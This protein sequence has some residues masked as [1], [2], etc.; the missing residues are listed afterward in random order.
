MG[1]TRLSRRGVRRKAQRTCAGSP[2]PL[3]S[4]G[5]A[6]PRKGAQPAAQKLAVARRCLDFRAVVGNGD[7]CHST[8]SSF[9]KRQSGSSRKDCGSVHRSSF[10]TRASATKRAPI[11]TSSCSL[12]EALSRQPATARFRQSSRLAPRGTAATR[13]VPRRGR[14]ARLQAINAKPRPSVRWRLAHRLRPYELAY[15]CQGGV[16]RVWN[17]CMTASGKACKLHEVRRQSRDDVGLAFDR[18][19]MGSSSPPITSVGHARPRGR[20]AC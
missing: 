20:K 5:Q 12:A 18:C 19:R 1:T 13:A 2:S 17:H 7:E 15:F 11:R 4:S 6:R 16:G 8:A 14:A 9:H 3:Q 10:P